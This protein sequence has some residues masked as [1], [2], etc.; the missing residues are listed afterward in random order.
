MCRNCYTSD[1]QGNDVDIIVA[2]YTSLNQNIEDITLFIHWSL[3]EYIEGG[4]KLL[5]Q[6]YH[7]LPFILAEDFKR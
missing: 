3:L 5:K 4:S 2:I 1:R 7:K 6:N